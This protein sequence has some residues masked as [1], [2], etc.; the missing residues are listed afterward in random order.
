MTCCSKGEVEDHRAALVQQ[1]RHQ[2]LHEEQSRFMLLLHKVSD[3]ILSITTLWS[4]LGSLYTAFIVHVNEAESDAE[5]F[6]LDVEEQKFGFSQ[7]LGDHVSFPNVLDALG[8][9]LEERV[10]GS[11]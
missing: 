3:P 10:G 9:F 1:K 11:P 7:E 5:M 8:S 2:I 4:A 6:Y